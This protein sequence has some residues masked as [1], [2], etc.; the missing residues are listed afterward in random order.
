MKRTPETQA[1][2]F[3]KLKQGKLSKKTVVKFPE[4]SYFHCQSHHT[5]LGQTGFA[6][7]NR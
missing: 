7:L 5:V 1:V 2:V 3:E 4:F 6:P